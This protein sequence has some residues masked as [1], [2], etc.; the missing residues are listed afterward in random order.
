VV[1]KPTLN[2]LDLLLGAYGFTIERLSDWEGLLR[3]NPGANGVP[4]YTVG[5]RITLL[6]K[7]T[8]GDG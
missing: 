6:A 7:N 2:G 4:D 5:R 1:G 8:A 3:D